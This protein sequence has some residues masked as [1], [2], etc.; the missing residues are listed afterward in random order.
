MLVG[1]QTRRTY[2]N[3]KRRSRPRSPGT[4]AVAMA[5][6]LRTSRSTTDDVDH[7]QDDDRP[8]DE[9]RPG[10]RK[11]AGP[12]GSRRPDA[13]TR[14]PASSVLRRTAPST[15]KG[16]E[17]PSPLRRPPRSDKRSPHD[18]HLRLGSVGYWLRHVAATAAAL[19][20]HRLGPDLDQLDDRILRRPR[21]RHADRCRPCR[22]RSDRRSPHTGGDRLLGS[23]TNPPGSLARRMPG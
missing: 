9:Q 18:H 14:L 21:R 6:R 3:A 20:A 13:S 16:A 17:A 15:T 5:S 10:H 22:P 23:S 7:D 2:S 12:R 11:A 19:A 1:S 4:P 8:L